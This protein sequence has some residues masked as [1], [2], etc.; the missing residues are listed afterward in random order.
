M[1]P[2]TMKTCLAMSECLRSGALGAG[3]KS[4]PSPRCRVSREGVPVCD[5][6]LLTAPG[7]SAALMNDGTGFNPVWTSAGN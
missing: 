6:P 5:G 2:R 3:Q 4:G 1:S 7:A